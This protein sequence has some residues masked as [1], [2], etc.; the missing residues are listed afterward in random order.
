VSPQLI[1]IFRAGSW[2]ADVNK[3]LPLNVF[4]F[5]PITN[6]T[7]LVAHTEYHTWSRDALT[8]VRYASKKNLKD[9]LW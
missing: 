6:K 2:T 4:Y 7:A 1:A 9:I 3:H 8:G 5:S